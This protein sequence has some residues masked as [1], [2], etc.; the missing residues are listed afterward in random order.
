[1]KAIIL[2]TSTGGGHNAAAAAIAEALRRR[3]VDASVQD[4]MAP[5]GKR[6]SRGV[7]GAY[8]RLVQ[9]NPGFF[10]KV[11]RA[12]S[13]VS[14]WGHPSPVYVFNTGCAAAL[15]RLLDEQQPDMVVCTHLFAGHMLTHL[16]RHGQYHGLT[17]FIMT[18]YTMIPFQEEV[19]CDLLFISHAD[20]LP[21]C[22]RRGVPIE[23]V[24]AY[25]IPVSADCVPDPNRQ[26]FRQRAGLQETG[27]QVLLV[28]GSM[29]AGKLPDTVAALLPALDAEAHLTIVCGS[30]DKVREE[31]QARFGADHRVTVRGEVRPLYPLLSSCDVLV[32][33]SGGLTSTEAMTIGIP[34][35]IYHPIEGCETANAAL[36][37]RHGM[38]LWPK[39]E[40][41]LRDAV[42]QLLRD[43]TM[44]RRMIACQHREID[45]AAADH[46]A[47][48]LVEAKEKKEHET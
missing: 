31:V 47:Q 23:S 30:N 38:A 35:V 32:T 36:F 27:S 11:Y 21:E 2:T 45:P 10:G 25:G 4:C 44:C 29:G 20:V 3:S 18:D 48:E 5:S 8:V 7:S 40:E 1:M 37:V 22:Q 28:G 15:K 19:C 17:A 46:I 12:G 33:K 9:H 34:L 16:Q 26:A 24:R 43:P 39:T 6:L 14:R 13:A 41:E 42:G